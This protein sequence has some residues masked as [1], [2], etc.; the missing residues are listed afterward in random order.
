L[1]RTQSDRRVLR[2]GKLIDR[3]LPDYAELDDLMQV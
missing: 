2:R 1:A 3:S